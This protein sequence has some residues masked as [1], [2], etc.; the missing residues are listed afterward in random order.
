[1]KYQISTLFTLLLL[2]TITISCKTDSKTDKIVSIIEKESTKEPVKNTEQEV[3]VD[4]SS[5]DY[6]I[7]KDITPIEVKRDTKPATNAEI[8]KMV[9]SIDVSKLN[10]KQ[11]VLQNFMKSTANKDYITAS[12]LLAYNGTDL[13]RKNKEPYNH[14][15]TQEL[16]IVKSTVDVVHG[17][18]KES[19]N[20][21]FISYKENG[22]KAII[23]LTF[24]KKSLG[25]NRHY[26]DVADTPNGL[27]I[28][29][30]R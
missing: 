6:K 18:L 12:R 11:K 23:E 19:N 28:V 14:K 10:E 29:G 8:H 24:F 21:Q 2:I 1:M 20:Y 9:S 16:N 7:I 25:M 13:K 5:K 15:N 22:D 26:F 27:L 3:V 17:F 4:I 30:M